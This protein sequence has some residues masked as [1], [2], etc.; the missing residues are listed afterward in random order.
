MEGFNAVVHL[1][2]QQIFEYLLSNA[3]VL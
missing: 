2:K 3:L 1:R